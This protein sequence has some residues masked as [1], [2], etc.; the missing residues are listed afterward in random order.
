VGILKSMQL[1]LLFIS[2][3][4][5]T[6]GSAGWKDIS[7]GIDSADFKNIRVYT[8]SILLTAGDGVYFLKDPLTEWKK[9]FTADKKGNVV[10][11][12]AENNEEN[13]YISTKHGVYSGK[14]DLSH[15]TEIFSRPADDEIIAIEL[16]Q[17]DRTLFVGTK[18]G[19]WMLIKGK[20]P[21][22]LRLPSLEKITSLKAAPF[23]PGII[24]AGTE[25]GLYKI[26]KNGKEIKIIYTGAT[27][28]AAKINFITLSRAFDDVLYIATD[29][30]LIRVKLKEKEFRNM[31]IGEG[32]IHVDADGG[33]PE[34]I[35]ALSGRSIHS[36]RGDWK[37]WLTSNSG[38][39]PGEL[40]V[41]K[42]GNGSDLY[43]LTSR[44]V[45]LFSDTRHADL[46]I[47]SGEI[48]NLF[49]GEP[50]LEDLE[51]AALR[52][53]MIDPGIIRRWRRASRIKALLPTVDIDVSS[54]VD[55]DYDLY[56]K[57]TI[58]TSSTSGR[59]YIGPEDSELKESRSTGVSY[60]IKLS[61]NLSDLVFNNAE[62]S[63]SN[64]AEEIQDFK[65]RTLNEVRR[66]YFERRRNIVELKITQ[67]GDGIKNFELKN[68]IE[69]L[70]SYLDSMTNGFFSNFISNDNKNGGS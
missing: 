28:N 10:D 18:S 17:T 38:L 8:N 62:L 29:E 40:R 55:K 19:L 43:L 41:L 25:R 44:G 42:F 54:G 13:I 51:R 60:G 12:L 36:S 58:Y 66:V 23:Q 34:W 35:L 59:Y 6:I 69:E 16:S 22:A 30:G 46:L 3:S 21:I 47:N 57:D 67:T 37:K 27:K 53:Q 50:P 24:F 1:A 48:N 15:W 39:P 26:S 9:I 7:E 52:A 49:H 31:G 32:I 65:N 5:I 68:R 11:A 14:P 4:D 63:V 45:F 64:E 33:N 70:T 56:L 2:I 61:W 20:Q